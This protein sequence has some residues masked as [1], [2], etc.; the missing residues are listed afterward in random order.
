MKASV[1]CVGTMEGHGMVLNVIEWESKTKDEDLRKY[2]Q[3]YEG[4]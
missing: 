3:V 2:E 4:H 1:L